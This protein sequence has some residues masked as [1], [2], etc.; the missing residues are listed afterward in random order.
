MSTAVALT[1]CEA[2]TIAAAGGQG[3][4]SAMKTG[5]ATETVK[6][7]KEE[8]EDC[9]AMVAPAP[10]AIDGSNTNAE[11]GKQQKPGGVPQT[12][13]VSCVFEGVEGPEYP[14][15]VAETQGQKADMPTATTVVDGMA[16]A[17]LADGQQADSTPESNARMQQTEAGGTGSIPVKTQD[18]ILGTVGAYIDAPA[19]AGPEKP[20]VRAEQTMTAQT[21]APPQEE[22]SPE[23]AKAAPGTAT[24]HVNDVPRG[25]PGGEGQAAD[26]VQK[27]AVP[28]TADMNGQAD[29]MESAAAGRSEYAAADKARNTTT[30]QSETAAPERTSNPAPDKTDSGV[31]MAGKRELARAGSPDESGKSQNV[32]TP[33][34]DVRETEPVA[35]D[36]GIQAAAKTGEAAQ[37]TREN[38]LRIVDKVSTQA[39][40][41]R[42]DFDVQLKPE[43]LGKVNIKLTMEDGVI[44]MQIKTD[45]MSVKGMLTDQ[46]SSLQSEL[47]EK[48]ITLTSVDVAYD[49][50][51]SFTGGK[52]PYEQGDG[53]RRQGGA[54][55]A[56]AD[57]AGYEPAAE[58]YSYYVGNSSVEFLA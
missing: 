22:Q 58:P 18:Q 40:E 9:E 23:A 33:G 51:A 53:G 32:T 5:K 29:T 54:Y 55:Y 50:Q 14:S 42:Y 30:T 49:T 7:F 2:Q 4:K 39:S 12:P 46:A 35:K 56:Q 36:A 48:G 11:T 25:M 15:D 38:V 21:A 20:A 8:L 3:K 17:R 24:T 10:A 47:R 27:Q 52:Q 1:S 31:A 43:F 37:Y 16:P 41:G 34:M 44:R 6:G 26:A 28:V 13:G 57:T 19:E 45:D